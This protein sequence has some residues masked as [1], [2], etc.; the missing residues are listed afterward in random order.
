MAAIICTVTVSLLSRLTMPKYTNA[1]REGN[2]IAEYYR[3]ADNG[4]R[5]DVIFIG[6]CEAYS[7]FSPPILWE[8][9]GITSHIRGSPSQTVEQSYHLLCET[10][11]Y[12]TPR[13][14][15][16][17]VYA[18]CKSEGAAE[19]YNRMTLDSMRMSVHKLNAVKISV[20][21]GESV[22]SYFLP[23]LRFHS[24]WT[25]LS[26]E[27]VKYAFSRPRVSHNGYFMRR[28]RVA[29]EQR[30]DAEG[31]APCCLPQKNMEYLE[32]MRALCQ[33]AGVELVLVKAPI[34]SWR[35]PWY[36]E[37]SEEIKEYAKIDG[38]VYYD[39]L[40]RADEIGID[41]LCDSYD[42]GLHLNVYGAE[43]TTRF[44]GE[45]LRKYI[46]EASCEAE[47]D[48]IWNEKLEIYYNERNKND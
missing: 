45:I 24:R 26:F 36:D 31:G 34:S 42:G 35:Y 18:L 15:V 33:I 38:V 20:G 11:E 16:F 32:K 9:Y 48:A 1:S 39:L 4:E 27:D 30:L 19:A 3:A 5:H 46:P 47:L 2:L 21:E 40:D 6:D 43:K 12:E 7:S 17:S 37:W 25:E 23:V 41:P 8:E 28:E 13:T 29:A 22:L 44:F 14:V 10:F